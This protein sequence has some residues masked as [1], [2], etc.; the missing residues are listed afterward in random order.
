MCGF[1]FQKHIRC[2]GIGVS[3]SD[4]F[5]LL[6]PLSALAPKPSAENPLFIRVSALFFFSK[7]FT[8]YLFDTNDYRCQ[9]EI[10]S[11]SAAVYVQRRAANNAAVFMLCIARCA[12]LRPLI[13]IGFMSAA[14]GHTDRT[15]SA[16]ACQGEYENIFKICYQ[17]L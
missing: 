7:C 6:N 1:H 13:C 16:A 15:A 9:T 8:E 17:I 12:K 14:V 11:E 4:K 5:I 10:L 2:G 3:L